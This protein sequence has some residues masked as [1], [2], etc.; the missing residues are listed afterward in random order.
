LWKRSG[1]GVHTKLSFAEI[2]KLVKQYYIDTQKYA[3]HT[4]NVLLHNCLDFAKE[5]VLAIAGG[6]IKIIINIFDY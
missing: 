3:A 6:F 4:Y 1:F 5:L 2:Y